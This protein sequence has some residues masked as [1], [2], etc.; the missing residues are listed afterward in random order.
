MSTTWYIACPETKKRV[1]IGQGSHDNMSVFYSDEPETMACLADFLNAHQG[2]NLV[3]VNIEFFDQLDY[4]EF[5][6][7]V[8]SR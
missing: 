2:K 5:C 4:E 6:S 1:W 3:V 8:V 7:E